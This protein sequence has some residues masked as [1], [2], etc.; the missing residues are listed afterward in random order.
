MWVAVLM[1]LIPET[2]TTLLAYE[3]NLVVRIITIERREIRKQANELTV[4]RGNRYE[5]FYQRS[6]QLRRIMRHS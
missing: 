5:G 4:Y 6:H 2:S 1:R 3:R